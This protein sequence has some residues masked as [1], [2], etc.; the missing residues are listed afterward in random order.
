M[1]ALV[2]LSPPRHH[3]RRQRQRIADRFRAQQHRQEED[4][5]NQSAALHLA[6]EH[7]GDKQGEEDN[8]RHV[9]DH[10]ADGG[11][12]RLLEGRVGEERLIVVFQPHEFQIVAART[13]HGQVAQG[14][15]HRHVQAAHI[16]QQKAQQPRQN[17]K[18]AVNG[19]LPRHGDMQL[20]HSFA[21]PV[22]RYAFAGTVPPPACAS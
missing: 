12:Q 21:P 11:R 10:V 5:A 18:I 6:V 15:L 8:Q 1:S 19:A 17:E 4:G 9:D 2:P 7:H 16:E 22:T 14:E 20:F 13:Q 3:L